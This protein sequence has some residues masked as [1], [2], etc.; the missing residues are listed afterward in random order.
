MRYL[1]SANL[2]FVPMHP[3]VLQLQDFAQMLLFFTQ[4]K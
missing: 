3:L 4:W 2:N 1:P